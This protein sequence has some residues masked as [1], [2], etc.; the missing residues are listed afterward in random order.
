[1]NIEDLQQHWAKDSVID[2][3]DLFS[4]SLNIPKLHEKYY[5]FYMLEKY[6]LLTMLGEQK[7]LKIEK[8]E[9]YTLG[10]TSDTPSHWK[11]PDFGKVV[12]VDAQRYVDADADVIEKEIASTMQ[13]EKVKFLESIIAGLR[14]RGFAIKNAIDMRKFENGA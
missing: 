6:R 1:M 7:T 2:K 13:L 14:E 4:E 10:P 8:Y 5:K 3:T 9:F 12:K 11:L